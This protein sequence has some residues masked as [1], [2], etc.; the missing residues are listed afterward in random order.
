MAEHLH[1]QAFLKKVAETPFSLTLNNFLD[2]E[3]QYYKGLLL[4]EWALESNIKYFL[5]DS[6]MTLSQIEILFSHEHIEDHT[7]NAV[8]P[9]LIQGLKY[10]FGLYEKLKPFKKV[11][12]Y[13]SYAEVDS[14]SPGWPPALCVVQFHQVREQDIIEEETPAFLAQSENFD[15]VI[16]T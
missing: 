12:V 6:S 1:D 8:E 10:T 13:M 2:Q 3:I 14:P 16:K 4:F 7:Q 9:T 5:Q 15:L 11:L